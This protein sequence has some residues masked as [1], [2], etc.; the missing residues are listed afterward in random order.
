[1]AEDTF[2]M[3]DV[4]AINLETP[5]P[6]APA[7]EAKAADTEPKGEAGESAPEG[8]KSFAEAFNEALADDKVELPEEAEKEPEKAAEEP[9]QATETKES[10][11]SSD[12]KKVKEDRDN[13]RRELEELKSKLS[14]LENSDVDN[15][16][17]QLKTE[18]DDLSQRLKLAA[19]ERHPK[20]QK[21]FQSKVDGVIEQAKR[22]VGSENA[23]RVAELMQMGESEYRNNSLDEMMMELSTTKQAQ[24][25]SLLTRI[26]EV[27][28]ERAS[29]LENAEQTYQQ[30]M[31]DQAKQHEAQLA[32][33]H[34]LFDN[35]VS[36]ASNLE[37]FANRDGDD[38]WNAEVKERVDM[39]RGI[40]SGENDPQELARASLWA[41]AG[42]KYRELLVQQ[43]EL[44]RR[45]Q[46]QLGDQGEANPSVSSN[47]GPKK[48]APKDFITAFNEAMGN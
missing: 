8:L 21:E 3:A 39:A 9:E 47:G 42:P 29:A 33:T 19:I 2:T 22:I 37:V 10:R 46:K 17:E 34:K 32:E 27:R 24:L 48:E 44:N 25:G 4:E 12:F 36:E 35:V 38:S 16:M 23:D 15:I 14:D 5:E 41:A 7:E 1:M 40:F 43:I 30:M 18:R 31:A 26:D 11:S 6:S 28:Y 13:A 20:F 45:L